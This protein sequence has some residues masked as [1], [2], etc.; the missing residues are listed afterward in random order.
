MKLL[1]SFVKALVSMA[2]V[3]LCIAGLI[4]FMTWLGA[5]PTWQM[6][7]IFTLVFVIILTITYYVSDE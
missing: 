4:F 5:L 7:A 6:I 2:V 3:M 1:Y